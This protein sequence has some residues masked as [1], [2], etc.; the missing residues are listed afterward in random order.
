MPQGYGLLMSLVYVTLNLRPE[1]GYLPTTD[2]LNRI[3]MMQVL[4]RFLIR[5]FCSLLRDGFSSI[6]SA[7][8][9]S[10]SRM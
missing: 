8:S 7:P 9:S 1:K 2:D 4:V 3:A 6:P 5:S 10:C